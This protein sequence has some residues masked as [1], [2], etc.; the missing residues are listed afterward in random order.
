MVKL[1]MTSPNGHG[2]CLWLTLGPLEITLGLDRATAGFDISW[3]GRILIVIP[4]PET[5]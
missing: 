3:R 2:R 4:P 5:L 1:S